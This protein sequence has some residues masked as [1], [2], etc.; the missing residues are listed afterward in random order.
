MK[1]FLHLFICVLPVAGL[2]AQH[3]AWLDTND[4][5]LRVFSNGIIGWGDDAVPWLGQFVPKADPTSSLFASG[6]WVS[7]TDPF[8]EVRSAVQQYFVLQDM[9]PGPLII[10]SATTNSA[11]SNLYDHVWTVRAPDVI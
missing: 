4:V 7:G 1:H 5:R 10:G 6:I 9:L 2:T 8:G 11:I 3:H